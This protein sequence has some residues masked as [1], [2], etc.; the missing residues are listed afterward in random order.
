MANITSIKNALR[1]GNI[2]A[3]TLDITNVDTITITSGNNAVSVR[4][5]INGREGYWLLKC[6]YR[7]K[8]N[9]DKIYREFYHP[10]ELKIKQ[11]CGDDEYIDVV[12]LPWVE[13]KPL[14]WYIGN[15]NADYAALS[16]EFDYLA[17]NT[18]DAPYAHGDVKPDN[19]IVDHNHMMT[20][21]DHDALWHPDFNI[22]SP[23]EIG[24]IG[25][26]HP[27]RDASY[28]DKRIDDYS[29]ALISTALAALALDRTTME[30]FIKADKTL[31]DPELCVKRKDEALEEA[32]HLFKENN[33]ITH[34]RIAEGLHTPTPF[35]FRL[36]EFFFYAI[37][38]FKL[39]VPQGCDIDYFY[40]YLGFTKDGKWV[41]PPLYE[42][43]DISRNGSC[44]VS[45]GGRNFRVEVVD[46]T[47]PLVE[48]AQDPILLPSNKPK[49]KPRRREVAHRVTDYSIPLSNHGKGWS[50]GE[51]EVLAIYLFDGCRL[52]NI[53]RWMGRS[54][55][56]IV[57]RIHKLKLPITKRNRRKKP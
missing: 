53:A 25:Y 32:K 27:R 3:R 33:D 17:Y 5:T 42:N 19:I 8:P 29:F 50:D 52:S 31:F 1:S 35:I 48:F 22:S 28:Y 9:L 10:Q 36:K 49:P 21:I 40:G 57:A 11:I 16:R 15:K 44:R 47:E 18:L 41:I 14:D 4:C 24:T 34:Y 7:H 45:F 37:N 13:G 38:P 46:K 43:C 12:A 30:R 55:K 2:E 56:A 26:R 20:L 54:E 39:E 23:S 6:Y 51:E